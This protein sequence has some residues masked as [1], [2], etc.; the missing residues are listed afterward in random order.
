[1][2]DAFVYSINNMGHKKSKGFP[3]YTPRRS[4]KVILP[5][6]NKNNVAYLQRLLS[7]SYQRP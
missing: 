7:Q 6:S 1:M 3:A 2:Q 4:E 5:F